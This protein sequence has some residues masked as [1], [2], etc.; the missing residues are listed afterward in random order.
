MAAATAV[1][2]ECSR[3]RTSDN[4]WW[5]CKKDYVE[6]GFDLGQP[7]R[8]CGR[9]LDNGGSI[10]F[11]AQTF[12]HTIEWAFYSNWLGRLGSLLGFLNRCVTEVTFTVTWASAAI[13]AERG[14][15]SPLHQQ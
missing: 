13:S 3:F 1:V 8:Y 15:R 2:V 10:T 4:S 7:L 11:E 6:I 5:G 12:V 9:D 14:P